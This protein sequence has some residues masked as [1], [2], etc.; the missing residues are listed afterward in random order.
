MARVQERTQKRQRRCGGLGLLTLPAVAAGAWLAY[1]HFYIEHDVPLAP[2]INADRTMFSTERSGRLHVYHRRQDGGRPLVLLHAIHAAPSPREM[3]S[4]FDA[5][6]SQRPVWALDLPGFGFSYRKHKRYTPRLY[7]NAILDLLQRMVQEP[8]DVVALSLTSE[9]AAM[10]ALEHPEAFHSLTLISPTGFGTRAAALDQVPL[11]RYGEVS[12][13]VHRAL[14]APIWSRPLYDL[15][16]TR[17]SIEW[18]LRKNLVGPLDD[19]LVDYAYDTAHQLGAQYAPMTFLSGKLFTPGVRNKVYAQLDV[20][21]QVIY[22][23]DPNTSFESL[24][25]FVQEHTNWHTDRIAPSAGLPQI[26]ALA[27]TMQAL[28]RFWASQEG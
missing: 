16:T 10:A 22:D 28:N 13:W 12:D 4:L 3:R 9:F 7:V 18:F 2:A 15:L 5:Y 25:S 8:A 24:G 19:E 11:T 23:Q 14:S 1:S 6:A 27:D 21:V 17:P 26:D 20:P